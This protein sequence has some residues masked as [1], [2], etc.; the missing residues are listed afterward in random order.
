GELSNYKKRVENLE[1]FKQLFFDME[2]NWLNAKSK[3][4]EY[5]TQL[6][7]M[8]EMVANKDLFNDVLNRYHNVYTDINA[9]FEVVRQGLPNVKQ[10]ETQTVHITQLNPQSNSEIIKLR[11]VA[12]DQHRII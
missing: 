10:V 2:K 4:A 7:G 5:Y 6:S 12:A 11:N 8:S 9:G 1:K 3:A